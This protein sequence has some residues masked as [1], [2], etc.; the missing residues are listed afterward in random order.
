MIQSFIYL[1]AFGGVHCIQF[2]AYVWWMR[3]GAPA[4]SIS[5]S[6][7]NIANVR[8]R[9]HTLTPCG[10]ENVRSSEPASQPPSIRSQ[11]IAKRCLRFDLRIVVGSLSIFVARLFLV[12]FFSSPHFAPLAD[13]NSQRH[14][15]LNSMNTWFFGAN[16]D[17]FLLLFVRISRAPWFSDFPSHSAMCTNGNASWPHKLLLDP[18]KMVSEPK[19]NLKR[20][21]MD[22][23][24][25]W[26]ND[27]DEEKNTQGKRK[28]ECRKRER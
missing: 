15:T 27:D 24:W 18:R 3:N 7:S 6:L 17:F 20:N 22:T 13:F 2:R 8:S 19:K 23:K 14:S 21:E 11:Q 10:R 4:L 26:T 16:Y 25:E 28:K 1:T 9:S 5:P 12:A